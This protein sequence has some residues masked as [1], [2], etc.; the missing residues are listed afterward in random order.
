MISV[1]GCFSTNDRTAG[2][3]MDDHKLAGRVKSALNHDP[4]YKYSDVE[5]NTHSGNVQLTGWVDL[6]DQRDK[7]TDIAR[8]VPGVI[9][10]VNNI[11]IK[12]TPTGH[13]VGYPYAPAR[14]NDVDNPER[15]PAPPK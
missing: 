13:P 9:D 6:P 4:T 1:T 11:L 3:V 15:E 7:A 5:V 14:T 10:L 12:R 8:Q 2:Q